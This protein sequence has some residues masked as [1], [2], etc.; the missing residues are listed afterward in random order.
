[1][2]ARS[3]LFFILL[4][5][6]C[7][8]GLEPDGRDGA[9]GDGAARDG[10]LVDLA[11]R[12]GDVRCVGDSEVSLNGSVRTPVYVVG[13]G[14]PMLACC[15]EIGSVAFV[16]T[17]TGSTV[18]ELRLTMAHFVGGQPLATPLHVELDPLPKEWIVDLRYSD[19]LGTGDN[20]CQVGAERVDG[21]SSGLDRFRGSFDVSGPEGQRRVSFCIEAEAQ[22]GDHPLL[23]SARLAARDVLL[24]KTF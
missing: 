6:A 23:K 8:S 20:P 13:N 12:D 18:P 5:V 7:R 2:R 1:M 10:A 22:T 11:R 16:L 14:T 17:Q 3:P 15:N 9:V 24:P 19:C 21:L 4:V